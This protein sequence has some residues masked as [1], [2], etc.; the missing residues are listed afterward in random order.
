MISARENIRCSTARAGLS[1]LHGSN[2]APP[3]LLDRR[4][5]LL[6]DLN[7]H[8]RTPRPINRERHSHN[9]SSYSTLVFPI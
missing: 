6:S 8:V 1:R 4:I 2:L 7:G 9:V 3:T 5:Q